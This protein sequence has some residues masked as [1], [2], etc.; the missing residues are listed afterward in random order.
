MVVFSVI[1]IFDTFSIVH[2]SLVKESN[3]GAMAVLLAG[4]TVQSKAKGTFQ[5]EHRSVFVGL[6]NL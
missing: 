2:G 4:S 3:S 5:R 1:I 6:I